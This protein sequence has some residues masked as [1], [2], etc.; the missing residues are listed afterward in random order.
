[1]ATSSLV[2]EAHAK[3]ASMSPVCSTTSV[4]P[5]ASA[6]DDAGGGVAHRPLRHGA[7]RRGPRR[8]RRVDQLG[9]AQVGVEAHSVV[10]ARRR[11]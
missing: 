5:S 4:A 3:G 2:T 10:S 9:V 1:M 8:A 6:P 11:A 7:E